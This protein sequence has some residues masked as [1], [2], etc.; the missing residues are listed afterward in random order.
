MEHDD[1]IQDFL[2]GIEALIA[3]NLHLGC[4]KFFTLK[5][6]DGNIIGEVEPYY[7]GWS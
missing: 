3:D 5:D 6:A 2:D 1:E 4:I 7:Y